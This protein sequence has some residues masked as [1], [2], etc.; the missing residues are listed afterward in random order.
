MNFDVLFVLTPLVWSVLG[1]NLDDVQYVSNKIVKKYK[2][3]K[4]FLEAW[5]E[6]EKRHN[7]HIKVHK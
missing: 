4:F 7:S 2:T 3:T 5:K 1:S 6:T